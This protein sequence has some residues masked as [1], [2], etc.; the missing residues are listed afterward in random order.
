SADVRAEAWKSA[1]PAGAEAIA[2]VS[3]LLASENPGIA[4]AAACALDNV[5]DYACRPGAAAE[6][7]AVA[8]ELAKRL[9][10][11]KPPSV[12]R[13]AIRL[14]A[15]CGGEAETSAVAAVLED[16]DSAM[17]EDARLTLDQMPGDAATQALIDALP[18]V[19][20]PLAEGVAAALGH[21]R[22]AKAIPALKKQARSG[23]PALKWACLEALARLGVPP[24]DVFARRAARSFEERVRWDNVRLTAAD[25]LAASGDP[26]KAAKL[27]ARAAA[28]SEEDFQAGAALLG[29]ACLDPAASVPRAI[30][31]LKRPGAR[32]A[33]V[34]VLTAA[35]DPAL[36]ASLTISIAKA[37]PAVQAGLL[38]V[39]ANRKAP[40]LDQL[41]AK[42]QQSPSAEV[43]LAAL[44]A[45]GAKPTADL[46]L[47]AIEKG[48]PWGRN[49]AAEAYLALAEGSEAAAAQAMYEKTIRA[50]LGNG[51]KRTAFAGLERLA[52][53]ESLP[54]LDE[55]AG[56][57]FDPFAG[58]LTPAAAAFREA[59]GKD[60]AL[61]AAAGRAYVA[62]HA[63]QGKD[64]AV[65]ALRAVLEAKPADD[66][67]SLV[68]EKLAGFGIDPQ[69]LVQSKG[70]AAK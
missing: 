37:G 57:L 31:A 62:V 33:A 15:L 42:A 29:L 4:K 43:R 11:A 14:L 59:A 26:G 12:R 2:P 8:A 36:D 39:L 60:T 44:D 30:E 46:L 35:N 25:A 27:Y 10:A 20:P 17:A 65:P 9:D 61:A 49:R 51:L 66:V 55:Y 32:V 13:E 38:E 67:N 50:D 34:Q 23:D 22:S 48:S 47:E 64:L 54:F 28:Q 3:E 69:T 24:K 21:R 40:M 68:V 7:T 58:R 41:L 19:A 45:S 18:R 70:G 53:A 1:G 5:V 16:K 56:P 63:L 52:R 6:K